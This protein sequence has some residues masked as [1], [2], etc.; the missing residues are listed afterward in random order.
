MPELSDAGLV[1]RVRGKRTQIGFARALGVAQSMVSDWERGAHAPS[2]DIWLKMARLTGYPL[3]LDCWGRAGLSELEREALLVGLRIEHEPPPASQR[4]RLKA[5]KLFSNSFP[6]PVSEGLLTEP[7][8]E[9][10]KAKSLDDL[11]KKEEWKRFVGLPLGK[12]EG[13]E[14]KPVAAA[15]KVKRKGSKSK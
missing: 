6:E 3:N 7:T 12:L 15:K 11:L 9:Q 10:D 1:R 5:Q 8:P 14:A 2:G 13:G 4:E